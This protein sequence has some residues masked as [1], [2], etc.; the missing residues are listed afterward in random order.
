VDSLHSILKNRFYVYGSGQGT[1]SLELLEQ[2]PD[3]DAIIVPVSGMCQ[4]NILVGLLDFYCLSY[5][6]FEII[7]LLVISSIGGGLISGI[8]LAAKA[9]NPCIRVFA[10]EPRGADD[11]AQSKIAGRIIKLSETNTI[12]DGLRAFL[13]DLTW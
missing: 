9:I 1:I 7:L 4:Q 12:A 3:I 13:G 6:V 11:A 8:T 5:V 2:V 10:A